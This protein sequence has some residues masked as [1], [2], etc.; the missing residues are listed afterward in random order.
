MLLISPWKTGTLR[1]SRPLLLA[2]VFS[3]LFSRAASNEGRLAEGLSTESCFFA[4]TGLTGARLFS[5]FPGLDRLQ[6]RR[7][8]LSC[9]S[10]SCTSCTST[11][12]EMRTVVQG[13]ALPTAEDAT[14]SE[15]NQRSCVSLTAFL[16]NIIFSRHDFRS[17]I[18][19][20][21]STLIAPQGSNL[22]L[23]RTGSAAVTVVFIMLIPVSEKKFLCVNRG[24]RTKSCTHAT[25]P[26]FFH[27]WLQPHWERQ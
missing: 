5:L 3:K 19:G 18:T 10:T 14:V 22:E 6:Q 8:S 4:T 15:P 23:C 24:W 1:Q 16:R 13:A 7:P 21:A 2:P 25:A 26:S 27:D 11:T 17:A 20:P 12:S 9:S